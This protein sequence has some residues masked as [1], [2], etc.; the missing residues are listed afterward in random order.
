MQLAGG[1]TGVQLRL[2]TL[3]EAAVAVSPTGAEGTAAHEAP[4]DVVALACADAAEEPSAS[5]ASTL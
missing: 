4:A 1:V 3:E 5:T 2:I